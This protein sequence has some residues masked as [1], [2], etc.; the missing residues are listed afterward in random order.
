MNTQIEITVNEITTRLVRGINRWSQEGSEL[1][2]RLL[3]VL[4]ME[5]SLLSFENDIAKQMFFS[6]VLRNLA[7]KHQTHYMIVYPPY[8]YE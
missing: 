3:S 5:I 6:A 4:E 2:E 8:I 1:K 7:I